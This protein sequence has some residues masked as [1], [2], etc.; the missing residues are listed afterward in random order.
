MEWLIIYTV[1]LPRQRTAS[2]GHAVQHL[3][4]LLL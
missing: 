4:V 2:E 3:H 1:L